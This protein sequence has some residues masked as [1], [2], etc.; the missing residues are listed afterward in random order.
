MVCRI[1]IG[2]LFIPLLAV[3]LVAAL[4]NT[5]LAKTAIITHDGDTVQV[6]YHYGDS[7]SVGVD[8]RSYH[9]P[10]YYR[11]NPVWM[12]RGY[13]TGYGY[14]PAAYYGGYRRWW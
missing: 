3:L 10:G 12:S 1:V 13:W 4:A 14:W 2:R 9:Y 11:V 8:Y 6:T 5:G 7:Y